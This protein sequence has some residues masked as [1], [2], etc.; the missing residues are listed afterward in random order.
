MLTLQHIPKPSISFATP[1]FQANMLCHCNNVIE[2][3]PL[4]FVVLSLV[5]CF[6]PIV[7]RANAKLLA[8]L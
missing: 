4:Y 1:L 6:L 3:R 2:S 5:I 7:L 8:R